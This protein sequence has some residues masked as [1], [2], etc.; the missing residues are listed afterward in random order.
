[1]RSSPEVVT[2][3]ARARV[4]ALEAA[5]S[6]LGSADAAAL[7]SLQDALQ[8]V[9]QSAHVH[10]VGERWGAC[11]Q[12]IERAKK[13]LAIADAELLKLQT[14]RAQL[15]TELAEGQARF[16]TLRVEAGAGAPS[17]PAAPKDLGPELERM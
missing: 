1:M 11:N 16:D 12:Y 9:K 5:V 7:K 4:T 14:E 6:A 17:H 10:P 2:E 13:R 3:A 15:A 8:K